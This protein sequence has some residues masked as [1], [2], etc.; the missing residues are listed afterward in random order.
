MVRSSDDPMQLKQDEILFQ[1]EYGGYPK[2]AMYG[3]LPFLLLIAGGL[4]VYANGFD[5]GMNIKG[6]EIPPSV[7]A[8]GI[9]PI[10]FLLCAIVVGTEIYRRYRPQQIVITETALILPKGRFTNDVVHIHWKHLRAKLTIG[11]FI[12]LDVYDVACIDSRHQSK[13]NISSPLFRR[14]DDFATFALIV[15]DF[16]GEDWTIK[17]FLPG[18]VCGNKKQ[19]Q[20]ASQRIQFGEDP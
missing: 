14:F 16:I 7:V 10:I 13:V 8:F 3:F 9:C 11:S 19:A 5:G 18:V 17:G 20:R 4:L 6:M 1:S 15:G 2:F 12:V